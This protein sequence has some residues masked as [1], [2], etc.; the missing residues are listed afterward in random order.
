MLAAAIP[1]ERAARDPAGACIADERE[2][3]IEEV[4]PKNAAGKT[5]KPMLRE[6][7]RAEQG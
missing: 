4:R 3:Y 1:D 6:R 7:L 2:V 5:A